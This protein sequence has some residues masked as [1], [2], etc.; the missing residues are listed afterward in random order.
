MT[1]SAPVKVAIV[2]SGPSALFAAE[3]LASAGIP[4]EIDI[5]ERLPC[6]F[7]LVRF[8]VAPDHQVTKK[9]IETYE[10]IMAAPEVRF[11]GNVEVGS[12]ISVPELSEIYDAVVLA[13]GAPIDVSLEI[14]GAGMPGHYGAGQFVNWYNGHPHYRDLNPIIDGRAAVVIGIGNVALDIARVLSKTAEELKVT[15]I[16][17]HAL[18]A[19]C[20][21][22]ITDIYVVGRRNPIYAR[23]TNVELR[24]IGTLNGVSVV[25]NPD[26][27]VDPDRIEEKLPR[28]QLKNIQTLWNFRKLNGGSARKRIHFEFNATPRQIVGDDRVRA[29]R[30]ERTEGRGEPGE[31]FEISCSTIVT[32]IGFRSQP[33]DGTPFDRAKSVVPNNSGRVF[34]GMYVVGWMKRGSQGVIGSN[35]PDGAAV[36]L[37]VVTD[38]PQGG[39]KPGRNQLELLLASRDVRWINLWEWRAIDQHERQTAANGSPRRKL[40]SVND[41]LAIV[42]NR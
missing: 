26:Q 9:V 34:P 21:S 6:P 40:T 33:I 13:A 22:P 37:H 27:L 7:G 5:L 35:K 32:A 41:M 14:P 24:E 19:I 31:L 11:Y 23:F 17:D 39:T 28:N 3:A 42:S 18:A 4:V 16:A 10:S 38:F 25:V 20:A 29:I 12:D 8:G 36:A 2:G 1:L 30:F 15:D